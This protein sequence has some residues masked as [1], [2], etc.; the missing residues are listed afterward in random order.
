MRDLA[1][2]WCPHFAPSYS[3]SCLPALSTTLRMKL[4]LA[5]KGVEATYGTGFL[6]G[7]VV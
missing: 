4:W 2:D 6:G 3:L 5:A 1:S 7:K